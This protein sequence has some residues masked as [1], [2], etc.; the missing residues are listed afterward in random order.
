MEKI[1]EK[2]LETRVIYD[3]KLDDA[4]TALKEMDVKDENFDKILNRVSSLISL[5]LQEENF[6]EEYKARKE[7]KEMEEI[8][9]WTRIW[10]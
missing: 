2:L 8:Y 10:K 5:M 9:Q 4:I 7:N 1:I 6:I 3:T